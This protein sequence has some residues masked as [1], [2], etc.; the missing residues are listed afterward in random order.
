MQLVRVGSEL[1]LSLYTPPPSFPEIVQ[2]MSVSE[3]FSLQYTPPPNPPA[4]FPVIVRFVRVGEEFSPQL[5]P[6]PEF[7]VT[8]QLRIV[9]LRISGASPEAIR[10]PPK[11]PPVTVRLESIPPVRSPETVPWIT[12]SCWPAPSMLSL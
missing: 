12:V 10:T 1:E 5:T 8:V 7:D 6:P 9:Q 4:E 2:F 11:V 3:E